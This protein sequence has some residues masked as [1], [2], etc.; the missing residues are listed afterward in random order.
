V[1]GAGS[2]GQLGL[3]DETNRLTPTLVGPEE[4][5]FG[6]LPVLTVACACTHTLAVTK[7]KEGVLWTFDTGTGGALCHNEQLQ[8]G[9]DAHQGAA[10]CHRQHR[11]CCLWVLALNSGDRLRRPLHL[12]QCIKPQAHQRAGEDSAH[13]HHPA[14]AKGRARWALPGNADQAR[15]RLRHGHTRPA[16]QRCANG[17]ASRRR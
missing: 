9:A 17:L 13:A 3:G 15:R 1:L 6:G 12:G 8:D 11:L 10:L 16:R 14:P 4:T 5:A 7:T 2:R